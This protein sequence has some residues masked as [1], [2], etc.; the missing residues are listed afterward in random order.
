[1]PTYVTKNVARK[2]FH[3]F[4]KLPLAVFLLQWLVGT[5]HLRT[6]LLRHPEKGQLSFK[7]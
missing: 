3:Y 4:V 5:F 2:H 6:I 1:M 7:M